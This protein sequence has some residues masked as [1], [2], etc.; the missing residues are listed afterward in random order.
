[1]PAHPPMAH[2]PVRRRA[3]RIIAAPIAAVISL[4]AVCGLL[5]VA[6]AAVAATGPRL[7]ERAAPV[8][9]AAAERP[10][11]PAAGIPG[12]TVDPALGAAADPI[13]ALLTARPPTVDGPVPSDLAPS[14]GAAAGD[15]PAPYVDGCHVP[16]D[17]R[18]PARPCVYGKTASKTTIVLF[19]DSHALAWFPAVRSLAWA[20]G[21][22]LV[23]LT[24]SACSPAVIPQWIPAA[25]HVSSAC[26][27]WRQ[28]ALSRIDQLR[29]L[30]TIVA[31]TRG[32]ATV[33]PTG[34]VLAGDARLAAWRAGMSR[35]LGRLGAASGRVIYLSDTPASV[36]D[37]PDCLAEHPSSVLACATPL[38]RALSPSWFTEEERAALGGGAD[39]I[40]TTIWTCPTSPCPATIGRYL[41][42][43]D[44]GH[45]TATFVASLAGGLR[46]AIAADLA[47]HPPRR[48]DGAPG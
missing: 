22:R 28:W 38:L 1:M 21:W 48:R 7:D 40:D 17:G 46:T 43:R 23:S 14:T 31:G 25:H 9:P 36:L 20:R 4:V 39:F 42:Y 19:G 2:R 34:Q 12:A 6:G 26:T 45:L 27:D 18:R 24:M 30:V 29:P 47:A 13:R 33:G 11:P 35:T 8:A 37:P 10:G 3:R 44:G 15:Y 32:F 16:M 5:G 41:V